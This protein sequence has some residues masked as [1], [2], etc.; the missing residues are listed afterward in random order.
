MVCTCRTI[1]RLIKQRPWH[2]LYK[3]NKPH[4]IL[5]DGSDIEKVSKSNYSS[6]SFT[7]IQGTCEACHSQGIWC[8]EGFKMCTGLALYLLSVTSYYTRLLNCSTSP[9]ILSLSVRSM[10]CRAY[11]QNWASS[12]HRVMWTILHQPHG[13]RSDPLRKQPCWQTVTERRKF[14]IIATNCKIWNALIPSYM[15]NSLKHNPQHGR[16]NANSIF[17]ICPNTNWMKHFFTYQA[18]LQWN[19]LPKDLRLMPSLSSFR[20]AYKSLLWNSC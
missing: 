20:R 9:W 10:H 8:P 3:I 2:Y 11:Y 18:M 5:L 19:R 4:S 14:R 16:R 13:I 12:E 1:C 17:V 15:H 6:W 7:I